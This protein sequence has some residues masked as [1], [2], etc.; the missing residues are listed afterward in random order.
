LKSPVV[1]LAREQKPLNVLGTK[2]SFLCEAEQTDNKWSIMSIDVPFEKGPPPHHHPW[3]EAYYIV[4][5]KIRF[6]LEDK[7]HFVSAGDFIYAPANSVHAFF[8]ASAGISKVLVFDS[9]STAGGFF[10]DCHKQ[11]K[12]LPS[13][14]EKMPKIAEKYGLNFLKPE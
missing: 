4:S 9:P 11:I 13:D 3:D 2:V 14:L 10:K 6:I 12:K 1:L 5:G 7:V 8:G